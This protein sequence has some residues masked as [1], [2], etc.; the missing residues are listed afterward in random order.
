MDITLLDWL[1][2]VAGTDLTEKG[3]TASE[4][5]KDAVAVAHSSG[6]QLIIEGDSA[7]P[8]PEGRPEILITRQEVADEE[9]GY[10][11]VFS[12]AVARSQLLRAMGNAA[13][14]NRLARTDVSNRRSIQR[15]DYVLRELIEIGKNLNAYKV[16]DDLLRVILEKSRH[17]MGADAG[18][19][20]V[21]EGED[22]AP[23][24][25][26]LHFKLMQNDS[27]SCEWSEFVM[28]VSTA[29]IAGTAVVMK[30]SINIPNVRD[31]PADA[32][33]RFDASWDEK[34]G[35]RTISVIAIPMINQ[36]GVVMGVIQLINKKR[37]PSVKLVSPDDFDKEVIPMDAAGRELVETLASQAGIAMENTR[38]YAEIK[39]IFS[40]FIK[41]SV[42]AIEQRDPTTSGH[43]FRVAA[44]TREL[45]RAVSSQ[46]D[47][48]FRDVTFSNDEIK[49]IET[50]AL[51][52][53]FGKVGVREEVLVK[54]KKLYPQN[55]EIIRARIDFIRRP[56]KTTTSSAGSSC[57]KKARPPRSCPSSTRRG[58]GPS[59]IST[60][61]GGSST[62]PTS[63]RCWR[64]GILPRWKKWRDAPSST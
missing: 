13:E 25:R 60:S 22:T 6:G 56:S 17:L 7:G 10:F 28:P 49:E 47:G 58:S 2:S 61:A 40:G 34:T 18:S 51:L 29:S 41:A 14:M 9:R 37:N 23:E 26:R 21:V 48:K 53:D 16:L 32:P 5:E 55:L 52:H 3:F 62:R 50:A 64:K 36:E 46:K 20:Y 11:A 54:A 57:S 59:A 12:P 33:Y 42:H 27:I 15:K 63:P 38:L 30:R 8:D 44:L 39:K 1:H 45:A 43:S 19:I 4:L 31:I 35:Y 24:Q